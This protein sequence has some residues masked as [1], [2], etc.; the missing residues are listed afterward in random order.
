MR[1]Y[2]LLFSVLMVFAACKTPQNITYMQDV[3]VNE[4][5][6]IQTDG[7]I[8]FQP[9]DKLSIYVHSRDPQL[10]DLF[11]L[12]KGSTGS[13]NTGSGGMYAYTVDNDGNID[14]PVLGLV[15]VQGLTRTEVGKTIKTRLMDENLCKDPVV[16]VTF[17]D[18]NFSVLGTVSGAGVKQITKDKITILEAIA[19]AND[20]QIDGLRGNVLVLRQEGDQQI[21]FRIDLTSAKSIYGS[22][23]YYIRQNDIVY[24]EPNNKNKRNSTVMSSTAYQPGFWFGMVTSLI[25][26]GSLIWAIL[27]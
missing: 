2:L 6:P 25:S 17:Y 20:L 7:S 21:P 12:F 26:A 27:K 13:T 11:N 19:M 16:T 1:K 4:P 5:I 18:M 9:G 15:R 14:F 3:N 10:M 8:R 24:V 23:A 22:P